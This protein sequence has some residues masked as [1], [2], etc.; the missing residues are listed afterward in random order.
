MPDSSLRRPAL[1]SAA[2]PLAC[3]V[4]CVLMPLATL[5]VP[6]LAPAHELEAVFM[7]VSAALALALTRGGVRA[8]GHGAVWAPVLLGIAVWGASI[9]HLGGPLPEPVTTVLGSVLLAGGMV[10][11]ARLRHEAECRSCGCPA[12]HH[13]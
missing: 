10:W 2:L 5:F 6:F 12:H 4:H 8:H 1:W 9:A 13:D 3:A 11:N 7:L